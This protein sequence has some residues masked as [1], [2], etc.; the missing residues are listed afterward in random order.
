MNRFILILVFSF[1]SLWGVEFHSYADALE[2][3]KTNKK[4]IMIKIVRDDCRYCENMQTNVCENAE[5]YKWLEER[6]I[7]VKVNLD[8][9][10]VPLDIKV[11]FTPSFYFVN[12]DQQIVKMIPGA[13]SIEDF[14]DLTRGIK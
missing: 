3:Q 1:S 10:D 7:L 5:M 6:F 12:K 8:K 2:I 13:W 9:N 4:I 14:K 11:S